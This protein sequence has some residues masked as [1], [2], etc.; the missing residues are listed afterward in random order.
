MDSLILSVPKDTFP[1]A[2]Y[3]KEDHQRLG[4]VSAGELLTFPINP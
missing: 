4:S 2:R 1:G 3:E